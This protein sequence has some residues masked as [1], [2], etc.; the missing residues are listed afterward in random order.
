M[1]N[2]PEFDKV[3]N[4]ISQYDKPF[5]ATI[6]ADITNIHIRTAHRIVKYMASIGMIQELPKIDRQKYF[7]FNKKFDLAGFKK[8]LRRKEGLR[9]MREYSDEFHQILSLVG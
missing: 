2:S 6:V 7:K 1:T 4:F 5:T 9:I 8:G 3:E